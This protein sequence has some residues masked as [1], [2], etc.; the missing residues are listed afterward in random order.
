MV[1]CGGGGGGSGSDSTDD[2]GFTS[3]GSVAIRWQATPDADGYI[4][5]W[6]ATSGVYEHELDVGRPM[7]DDGVLSFV[8]DGVPTPTTVYIAL[9]SY[10]AAGAESPFSNELSTFVP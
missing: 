1:A 9:T 3:T 2:G 7:G 8:L 4:I 6:G 10:D 5:H